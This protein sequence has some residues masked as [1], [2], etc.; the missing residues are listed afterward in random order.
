M[1]RLEEAD[2]SHGEPEKQDEDMGVQELAS[3]RRAL[4]KNTVLLCCQVDGAVASAWF[5]DSFLLYL[6]MCGGLP[7]VYSPRKDAQ[8]LMRGHSTPHLLILFGQGK[9][10]C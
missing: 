6:V 10:E 7:S 2:H 5:S 3:P 8:V 4:F 9:P 1:Q